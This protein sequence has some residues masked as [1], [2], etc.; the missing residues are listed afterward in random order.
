MVAILES[1]GPLS[2]F[3]AAIVICAAGGLIRGFSGFG[4]GLVLTPLL[5]LLYGASV[6]VP[7]SVLVNLL[8]NAQLMPTSHS[9]TRWHVSLP[10]GA[11]AC[12]TAPLGVY[13]LA[14]ADAELI[15]RAIGIAVLMFTLIIALGWT[16]APKGGALADTLVGVFGGLLNGAAA[17]GGA[18]ITLYILGRSGAAAAKRADLIMIFAIMHVATIAAF[19]AAGLLTAKVLVLSILVLPMFV[20]ASWAG[21]TMFRRADSGTYDRVAQIFLVLVGLA[22]AI[23]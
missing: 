16:P 1:I 9:S 7:V 4:G 15:R 21:T 3:G 19:Y 10:I 13:L 6:A 2:H 17:I 11:V 5:S 23:K 14:I 22:A 12:L 20:F 18:P 8:V